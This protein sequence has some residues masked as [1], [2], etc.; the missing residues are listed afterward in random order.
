MT[1][2]AL[3]ELKKSPSEQNRWKSN[4]DN[5]ALYFEYQINKSALFQTVFWPFCPLGWM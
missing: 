2:R 5:M 1:S 3:F 4:L